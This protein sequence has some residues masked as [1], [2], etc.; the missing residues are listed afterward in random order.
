MTDGTSTLM[1]GNIQLGM[2]ND[3]IQD[4]MI[5]SGSEQQTIQP[6]GGT[7]WPL[8]LSRGD[9]QQFGEKARWRLQFVF[10]TAACTQP[11]IPRLALAWDFGQPQRRAVIPAGTSMNTR[12]K[13]GGQV[14]KFSAPKLLT[15]VSSRV[16]TRLT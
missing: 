11:A 1:L 6:P 13:P 9:Q 14:F 8:A 4:G 5:F 7:S 3:P 10:R 16:H 12:L 15:Q 2:L